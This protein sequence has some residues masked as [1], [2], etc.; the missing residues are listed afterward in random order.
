MSNVTLFN[1]SPLPAHLQSQ[2]LDEV[3]KKLLG[4]N[5][6]GA[7]ISY[8]GAVWRMLSGGE[9]IAK[10][11]DRAMNVVIVN[12][13]AENSRTYYAGTYKEGEALPPTCWSTNGIAPEA[14][15]KTKQSASCATCKK[16][17]AGS[18]GNGQGRAC[19][20]SRNLAVTLEN[21]PTGQ[22]FKLQLAATSIFGKIENGVMPLD[23]YVKMLA[24]QRCPITA[25]VTEMKFDTTSATPKIG[26]KP[27]R[28]LTPDEYAIATAKGQTP[29]AIDA[30]HTTVFATDFGTNTPQTANVSSTGESGVGATSN[31]LPGNVPKVDDDEEALRQQM[32]AL[33]S[34]LAAKKAAESAG[35]GPVVMQTKAAATAPVDTSSILQNWDSQ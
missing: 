6:G 34:K 13:A 16:N 15:V 14:D 32:A 25:V 17:V 20:Y 21:D 31:P 8:K 33:Q 3:T 22:V 30:T 1:G 2:E 35:A 24:S 29:E 27:V 23:A 26:F 28:Y 10:N 4:K 12:A 9:E 11:E 18:G 5:G 19:R 7:R